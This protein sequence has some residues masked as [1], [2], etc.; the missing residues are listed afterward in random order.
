MARTLTHL[1]IS[2]KNRFGLVH[3]KMR[4]PHLYLR[5]HQKFADTGR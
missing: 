2:I 4:I 5:L 3:Q 1:N